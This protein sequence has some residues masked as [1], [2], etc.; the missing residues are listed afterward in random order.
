M[1]RTG[2]CSRREVVITLHCALTVVF[3]NEIR[4]GDE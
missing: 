2:R 3:I 4:Y 1:N